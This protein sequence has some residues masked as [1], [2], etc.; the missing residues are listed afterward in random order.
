MR[1]TSWSSN[2]R[3]LLILALTGAVAVAAVTLERRTR[4]GQTRPVSAS[5]EATVGDSTKEGFDGQ[6]ESDHEA[7]GGQAASGTLSAQA[8]EDARSTTASERLPRPEQLELDL[9]EEASR[10]GVPVAVS[11]NVNAEAADATANTDANAAPAIPRDVPPAPPLSPKIAHAADSIDADEAMAHVKILADADMA[12]RRAGEAGARKA[13]DYIAGQFRALGLTPGGQAGTYFQTFHIRIGY[14]IAGRFDVNVGNETDVFTTKDDFMP[15]H[16]PADKADVT[17]ACVLAGF[18]I[19]S[20]ELDFDEYA[21]IDVKGKAAIVFAGVPWSADAA[22]WVRQ[23][24][25]RPM[26]SLAYKATTAAEHGATLLIVVDNPASSQRQLNIDEQLGLPD[27]DFPV[28]SPIPVVHVTRAAA[29]RLTGL[30]EAELRTLATEVSR[31]QRPISRELEGRAVHFEASISGNARL[32][33]NVIAIL[34]GSDRVLRQEAVVLG[35]HYDHL[36]ERPSGTYFGANDNAA[37]VAALLEIAEAFRALPQPPRRSIVFIAF[38]AEEI[39][40]LGSAH[41][42]N[43]PTIPIDRTVAMIN[44]DMIARNEKDH[45]FAVGTRSSRELH[46]IHQQ[47][48]QHVG[49]TLEHPMRYRLGLSDHTSFYR[50]DVPII[51]LFG[52]RHDGYHTPADTVDKLVP[53]KIAKVARLAFLTARAVAERIE[54]PTFDGFQPQ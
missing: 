48:N 47:M 17:A 12:G 22:G 50:K 11:A 6:G 26:D 54:R 1:R 30:S 53:E 52:G 42:V 43:R 28:D 18:G 51:Y 20:K 8:A 40:R 10:F 33:R 38:A 23:V 14:D 13:A 27:R 3:W 37:G 49:L 15:V 29:S 35:A 24:D 2:V 9:I 34:P 41:Y 7:T 19:T 36:G 21:R 25:D 32:G 44:F 39:G 45:I 31:W 16:L 46:T 4:A 5:A